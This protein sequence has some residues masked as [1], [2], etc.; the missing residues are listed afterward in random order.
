MMW[1]QLDKKGIFFCRVQVLWRTNFAIGVVGDCDESDVQI[2]G[3]VQNDGGG[4]G[5]G[6]CNFWGFDY[7][8]GNVF[9]FVRRGWNF[10]RE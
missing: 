3:G 6:G 1:W 9:Y 8:G 10:V 4:G 7:L 5:D 2:C